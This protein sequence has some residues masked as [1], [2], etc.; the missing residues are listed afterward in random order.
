MA[1][2]K[3]LRG[4]ENS[5]VNQEL[6][7]G[8]IW[9]CSDSRCMYIDHPDELGNVT[10]S[11]LSAD[12]ADRLR[13]V[14]DGETVELTPEEISIAIS[15]KVD[16]IEGKGLSTNDYTDDEKAKLDGI[17]DG[18]TKTIVDSTLSSTSTN[19]VQNKVVQ[20]KFDTLQAEIDD[21]AAADHNHDS[22]YSKTGHTHS[23][24]PLS[25]GTI[26]GRLSVH[27]YGN[28]GGLN[29]DGYEGR[30]ELRA[31]IGTVS[32]AS[33]NDTKKA[34]LVLGANQSAKEKIMLTEYADGTLK[35]Y[36]LY[37]EHNKPTAADVG[38]AS[39]MAL[40]TAEYNT[41]STNNELNESTLYMLTDD[42]S[43]EDLQATVDTMNNIDYDTYLAFDTTEIV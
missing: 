18:A 33:V 39:T 28:N 30:L 42:T 41:M 35:Q 26:D 25:G 7:D 21:K 19:P 37:G 31:E 3:W 27:G 40:T 9:F 29:L 12:F 22:V 16:K 4:G 11:K 5:L 8:Y 1:L 20:E 15:N 14:Q 2:M 13:Y 34:T 43:E 24:L 38:A 36:K 23:Y 32:I 17:E 6:H 10:R